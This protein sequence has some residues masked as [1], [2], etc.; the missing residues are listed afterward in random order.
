MTGDF[1]GDFFGDF[2]GDFWGGGWALPSST[3]TILSSQQHRSNFLAIFSHCCHILPHD[4]NEV[5]LTCW[6]I[7]K[8]R[9]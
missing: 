3:A 1:L 8:L 4:L 6:S 9:L 7:Q 2:F 5:I